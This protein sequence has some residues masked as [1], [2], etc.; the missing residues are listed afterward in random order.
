MF[1]LKGPSESQVQFSD[2]F[3]VVCMAERI[4][5]ISL[6]WLDQDLVVKGWRA[7]DKSFSISKKRRSGESRC[8]RLHV[9]V[10]VLRPFFVRRS[11]VFTGSTR[12]ETYLKGVKSPKNSGNSAEVSTPWVSACERD[13]QRERERDQDRE[14]ERES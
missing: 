8:D 7:E 6:A 13:R 1:K 12:S 2:R 5:T 14:R 10:S 11:C 3:I 4:V 9:S